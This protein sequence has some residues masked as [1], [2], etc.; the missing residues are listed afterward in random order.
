MALSSVRTCDL[1][2]G[3]DRVRCGKSKARTVR[4]ARDTVALEIDLCEEHY[5]ADEDRYEL[6]LASGTP[7]TT[8]T[9]LNAVVNAMAGSD[10]AADDAGTENRLWRTRTDRV[11]TRKGKVSLEYVLPNNEVYPSTH[12]ATW[13]R[14]NGMTIKRGK[15]PHRG[16]D[17]FA[18]AHVYGL[19]ADA[20]AALVDGT[21][22]N[23]ECTTVDTESATTRS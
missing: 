8:P 15:I 20:V 12:V 11:K 16:A 22:K 3:Q 2:V 4:L 13:L 18:A 6:L 23:P 5:Q 7:L 19:A 14:E 1:L 17:V 21:A 9:M 10:T